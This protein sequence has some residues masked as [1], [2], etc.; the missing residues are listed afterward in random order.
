MLHTSQC[1]LAD[2]GGHLTNR[3]TTNQFAGGAEA[4]TTDNV[5]TVW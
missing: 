1:L 4:H 5:F 2:I 3:N